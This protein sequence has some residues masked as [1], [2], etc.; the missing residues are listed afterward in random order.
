MIK[1]LLILILFLI[2]TCFCSVDLRYLTLCC[3]VGI[4]ACKIFIYLPIFFFYVY[5]ILLSYIC[6]I[7]DEKRGDVDCGQFFRFKQTNKLDNF[8]SF[9]LAIAGEAC[10]RHLCV[11]GIVLPRHP[12]H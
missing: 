1:G 5:R 10:V 8:T 2:G 7:R 3:R 11:D 12:W 4:L 9:H 6:K